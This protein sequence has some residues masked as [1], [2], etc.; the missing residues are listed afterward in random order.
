MSESTVKG[1]E[2]N[3]SLLWHSNNTATVNQMT[4]ASGVLYLFRY[5]TSEK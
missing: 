4:R 5:N 3:V 1:K 2:I